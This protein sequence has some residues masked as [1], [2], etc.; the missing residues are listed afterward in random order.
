[1][2]PALKMA[3]DSLKNSD[4]QIKHIIILSDGRSLQTDESFGL[5]KQMALDSITISSVVVSD[6]ADKK[7]MQ[8][9]ANAGSGRYYE[10]KDA[11]NLPKLFI[12]ET[13]MASK[14]I[15]EGNIQPIVHDN[16]EI[17]RGIGVLPKLRGYIGTSAKEGASVILKSPNDDPILSAWQY[18][19]GR[20]I[21][22]TSDAQPK[23]ALEWLKWADFGKFWH[24]A[25]RWCMSENSGEFDVAAT[26][27][28]SKGLISVDA[29]STLG[30]LRNFLN[31][32]ASIVKPDLTSE[33][34]EL[35]QSGSGRYDAEFIADQM[36]VFLISVTEMD[37]G[38]P[39]STKN[40]GLTVSYSPEYVDLASNKEFM[41]NLALTTGG[42]FDPNI[43]DITDRR[44]KSV[45]HI[46]EIWRWLL[47]ISIPLFFF[48][49]AIRRITI[50]KEQFEEFVQGLFI[51]NKSPKQAEENKTFAYLKSR[52]EKIEIKTIDKFSVHE[53]I[54]TRKAQ[55]TPERTG[56]YT[57]RLLEAKKRVER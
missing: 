55:A 15:T 53:E 47:I 36:G 11:A 7:F 26:V 12:K 46:Q 44:S 23:W 30:Q 8:N 39:I 56:S 13:F 41:A 38:K 9:I 42:K 22:F 37:D 4:S 32:S 49:V 6:E 20:S 40:V 3:Y 34:I 14:L 19:L 2:Y 54:P 10:T 57:S 48:D 18:G 50:S 16:S 24:Q 33:T 27:S 52:K 21:A 51:F 28:G 45:K 43:S 17:L 29:V 35:K 1:M 5:V 25:V 31:F